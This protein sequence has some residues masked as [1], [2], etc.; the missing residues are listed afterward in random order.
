LD[1][2]CDRNSRSHKGHRAAAFWRIWFVCSDAERCTPP[3]RDNHR[4][5]LFR[6]CVRRF[7]DLRDVI[8]PFFQENLCELRARELREVRSDHRADGSPSASVGARHRGDSGDRTDDESSKAIRCPENP[9]RP[10]AGPLRVSVRRGRDGPVPTA[11]WGGWQTSARLSRSC[12]L[13]RSSSNR[14][15]EIPCRVSSDLH[16]WRNDLGAVSTRDSAKLHY[17]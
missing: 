5:D 6:Y 8:V 16:E 11:T 4:E 7:G 10:Y 2:R 9:Q 14:S 17:E 12:S 15:S 3:R 13:E 1:G